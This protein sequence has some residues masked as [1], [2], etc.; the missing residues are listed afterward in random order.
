[1]GG[2]AALEGEI[3]QD[4]HGWRGAGVGGIR[5]PA[6]EGGIEQAWGIRG[7]YVVE[8]GSIRGRN[9]TGMGDSLSGR[10]R[11]GMMAAPVGGI[12]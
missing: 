2:G 12:E 6:P 10:N 9:R 4:R 1:M 7:R 11:A 8:G 3:Q 5:G